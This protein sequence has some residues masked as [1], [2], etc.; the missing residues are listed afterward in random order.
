VLW[1]TDVESKCIGIGGF[2]PFSGHATREG[3]ITHLC[4]SCVW[5]LSYSI[6]IFGCLR[7]TS[8]SC[9]ARSVLSLPWQTHGF[10]LQLALPSDSP[11]AY[12]KDTFFFNDHITSVSIQLIGVHILLG[13]RKGAHFHPRCCLHKMS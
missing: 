2:T 3:S 13:Y 12:G 7:T 5:M 10:V 6:N 8:T 1:S 4:R 9:L 11:F